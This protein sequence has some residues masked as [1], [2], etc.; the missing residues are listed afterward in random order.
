MKLF[1]IDGEQVSRPYD[2]DALWYEERPSAMDERPCDHEE[3]GVQVW[4]IAEG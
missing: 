4:K 1:A 2:E 3:N